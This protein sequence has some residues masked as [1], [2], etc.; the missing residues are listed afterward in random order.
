MIVYS[1][2]CRMIDGTMHLSSL[3]VYFVDLFLVRQIYS[4]RCNGFFFEQK[5]NNV[6]I[7]LLQEIA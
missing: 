3:N 4:K 7:F 6:I 2:K 5:F 1:K